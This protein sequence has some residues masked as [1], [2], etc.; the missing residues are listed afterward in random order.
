MRILTAKFLSCIDSTSHW[1]CRLSTIFFRAHCISFSFLVNSYSPLVQ[2]VSSAVHRERNAAVLFTKLCTIQRYLLSKRHCFRFKTRNAC[3]RLSAYFWWSTSDY[4]LPIQIS[5][6]RTLS[7]FKTKREVSLARVWAFDCPTST[8]T[9][10]NLFS[11]SK[12]Y[13]CFS[14]IIFHIHAPMVKYDSGTNGDLT[15]C[16]ARWD[17]PRLHKGPYR[18]SSCL[19]TFRHT[20]NGFAREYEMRIASIALT[21]QSFFTFWKCMCHHR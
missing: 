20:Y 1:R 11:N 6:T 21:I 18:S 9:L 3:F 14:L 4:N 17:S 8:F 19:L 15:G 12:F 5:S 16:A 7:S 13:R 2:T 10:F